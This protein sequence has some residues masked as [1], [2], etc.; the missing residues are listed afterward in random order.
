[1]ALFGQT[2]SNNANQNRTVFV[3]PIVCSLNMHIKYKLL[4]KNPMDQSVSLTV[5]E[6]NVFG[7]LVPGS[8]VEV[9]NLLFVLHH[10]SRLAFFLVL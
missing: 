3:K 7:D 10:T 5:I 1:M 8:I 6:I 2:G 9:A 4:C